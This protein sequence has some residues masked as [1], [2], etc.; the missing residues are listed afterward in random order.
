MSEAL[1]TMRRSHYMTEVG[2]GLAGREVTVMG[3]VSKRRALGGGLT[4][5]VLRDRTG[6]LQ[7]KINPDI[8]PPDSFAKAETVRS[9][10][11]LAARGT[12]VLRSEKDI[13]TDMPSGKVEVEVKELRVLS[14]AET[15]PFT[16]LDEGVAND[17]RLKYRYLDLRRPKMQANLFFRHRLAQEIRAFYTEEGF[18]EVETPILTKSTPEGARDY[19]VPSREHPGSFYALPQSPQQF[20]QLLMIAGLD[21]YFQIAKCFRDEDLRAD[22]QPEFTQIDTEMSFIDVE[23]ILEVHERLIARIFSKLMGIEL[24]TPFPRLPYS[25]AMQKYGTDKPDTRFSLEIQDVSSHIAR[26]PSAPETFAPFEAALTAGGSVRAICAPNAASLTRKQLDS[27]AEA[28]K[29]HGAKGVSWISL[30][31]NNEIKSSLAK[32]FPPEQLADLINKLSASPGALVL[33]AAHEVQ[34]TVLESMGAM[35]TKL[36]HLLK[37]AQT[38]YNLLWVTDMPLLEWNEEDSRF[39]A[40]HHPFTSPMDED[41]GLL[42]TAPLSVRAKAYDL[43]LNGYEVG[44]GSIRIHRKD[45]QERMFRALSFTNEDMHR[46]FG[47]FI[48]AF[49]YGTPPHGGIALGLDRLAM[50]LTDSESL[51]DIIA[52]PKVKDASCPMT[53]APDIV[54]LT[55]L[56]ELGLNSNIAKKA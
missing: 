14:Q 19:L 24:Q 27:L 16:M 52:F 10:Y 1:N 23:D 28:G 39:Y 43:V 25:E 20:K 53:Q 11:V 6:L 36:A 47:Y 26:H 22:R 55:Q 41:L 15:P 3:W 35:R 42:E 34:D 12:V 21:K 48:E 4:F 13:N 49:K 50:L 31:N 7:L 37:L 2:E 18:I 45:V 40:K 8:C 51:R 54:D 38:G 44:G 32:F 33:L 30:G 9:E 5:I 29:A 46:R 17:T 56:S